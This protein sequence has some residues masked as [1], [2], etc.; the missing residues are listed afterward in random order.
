LKFEYLDWLMRR[1]GHMTGITVRLRIEHTMIGSR[2]EIY[3]RSSS[4][5]VEEA[6]RHALRRGIPGRT[7]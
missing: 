7:I 3:C 5:T 6:L 2:F 1:I 4:V